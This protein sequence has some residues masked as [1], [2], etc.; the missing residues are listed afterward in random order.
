MF[1]CFWSLDGNKNLFPVARSMALL[2]GREER[3][4]YSNKNIGQLPE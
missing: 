4:K 2:R 1:N 3:D